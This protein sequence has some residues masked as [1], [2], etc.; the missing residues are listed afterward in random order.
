M[1]KVFISLLSF[2]TFTYT[3][4]AFDWPQKDQ[5]MSD[6]FHSYFGQLRGNTISNS[7]TFASPSEI[8]AVDEGIISIVIEDYN[9]NC[10]FFPS[11]LGNAIIMEHKDNI[12]TIYGN[13]DSQTINQEIFNSQKIEQNTTFGLSGNSGWQEGNSSLEFQVIDKKNKTYINPRILMPRIGKELPLY[14]SEVVLIGKNNKKHTLPLTSSIPTGTY[15]VYKKRQITSVPY[16]TN[17]LLNGTIVDSISYDL[18]H[19]INGKLCLSGKNKYSKEIV[20]P[21]DS[22]QLIGETNIKQG[23]N[24]LGINVVNILQTEIN[25]NYVIT[26]Y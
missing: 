23:R 13:I 14:I 15:K 10:D 9:D 21:D 25:A 12:T 2:L 17:L 5:I 8:K 20:Y 26:V 11:T 16:K 18:L 22:L 24:I 7:L 1:K 4:T 3:I 6:S 19:Q